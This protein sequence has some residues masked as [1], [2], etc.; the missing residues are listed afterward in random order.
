MGASSKNQ[1]LVF[2]L[3]YSLFIAANIAANVSLVVLDFYAL[4]M[5]LF[6]IY[7]LKWE[8]G[9]ELLYYFV[10]LFSVLDYAFNL[11]LLGRFN[12]YYL[13][14]A[15]FILVVMIFSGFLKRGQ[16]W[17]PRLLVQNKYI[18]FLTIFII[19]MVASLLWVS[20]LGSA[21]KYLLNY[22]IMICFLS[23]VYHFNYDR[24]KLS[25]TLKLLF[26][27]AGSVLLLGCFEMAGLRMPFRNIFTDS[28]WYSLGIDYLK[29]IPT[30]F[31]YNPN[32][33]AVYLIM[34]MSFLIPGI[35]FVRNKFFKGL[36]VVMQ[37]VCLLNLIFT[38]SRTAWM[39]MFLTVL[40]F[41]F[42]FLFQKERSKAVLATK[43]GLVTL[44]IFYVL[45]YVPALDVYYGKFN[46]TPILNFLSLRA[47]RTNLPL[48][49]LNDSGSANERYTIIID[50]IKGVTLEGHWQ[51]FGVNN[52]SYYLAQ[53]N[54]THGFFN[55]HSL[56]FEILGDF[57]LF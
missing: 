21:L 34:L 53:L 32:N 10:L 35:I 5:G 27:T 42:F 37:I 38:T 31:F 55:V 9:P 46:D 1:K 29:T 56:W 39:A 11:P 23:A 24:N 30:V 26:V 48:F 13:H 47:H 3:L 14:I 45:S 41:I 15:L 7:K 43:I 17:Q 57:G 16:I 20:N 19:Y 12:I 2:S 18:L 52:T 4:L 54:N 50:V 28:G 51:G 25:E 49:T 8:S 40:G 36:L 6:I 22:L 33:Y 44:I